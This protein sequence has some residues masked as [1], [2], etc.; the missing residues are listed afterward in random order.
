LFAG[1]VVGQHG[2]ASRVVFGFYYFIH[3]VLDFSVGPALGFGSFH[4]AGQGY[5][6]PACWG[7][8]GKFFADI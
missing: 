2:Q 4:E 5:E 8:P 1:S 3:H 6:A 7:R